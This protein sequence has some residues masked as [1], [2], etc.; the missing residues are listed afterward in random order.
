MKI[1]HDTNLLAVGIWQ[2]KWTGKGCCW[3][4]F[5][6]RRQLRH[7]GKIE[8]LLILVF[9]LL[10]LHWCYR[11]L[12]HCIK[13]LI[14]CFWNKTGPCAN[15][16]PLLGQDWTLW[17]FLWTFGTKLDSVEICVHFLDKMMLW[18]FLCTCGTRQNPV[19]ICVIKGILIKPQT[20]WAYSVYFVCSKCTY[21]TSAFP[22]HS[23]LTHCFNHMWPS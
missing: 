7:K 6:K 3:D 1:V 8:A 11:R 19:E 13:I 14:V 12:M 23:A 9:T 20:T 15:L 21:S 18:R 10:D 2:L 16:C 17:R 4:T 22:A 5:S